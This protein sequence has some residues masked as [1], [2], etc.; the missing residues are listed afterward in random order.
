MSAAGISVG[1]DR[2]V[3]ITLR[4]IVVMFR[5][6]AWIWSLGLIAVMLGRMP[7]VNRPVLIG[8]AIVA[9]AWTGATVW[10]SAARNGR[11]W[12][13]VADGAIVLALSA[14]G[15]VAGGD[16]FI[17]GGLPASSLFVVAY[18][19]NLRWTMAAS[20]VVLVE[21]VV[22]HDLQNLGIQRT[23]GTYQFLVFGL[24]AGWSFDALRNEERRRLAAEAQLDDERRAAVRLEQGARLGQILHDSVLQTLLAIK[25]A[26]E[27][28]RH[29][30]YLARWQERELRR[31]I[32]ELR[33]PHDE[34]F[35]VELLA[36]R[37]GVEDLY[38]HTRVVD[39]IRD[40]AALTPSLRAGLSAAREA[41]TNAAKH[42]GVDRVDLYAEITDGWAVI[43]IRDRGRG[44]EVPHASAHQPVNS[45]RRGVDQVGGSV[46]IVTGP[47]QGTE[48][49]IRVPSA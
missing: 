31:T 48:V 8:A 23:V 43:H 34:S 2:P 4:W 22:L 47:G 41:L 20:I 3:Q 6:A 7:D 21:H 15:Y 45:M 5:V 28:P 27:D 25:N 35:R 11:V 12:F 32:E 29:V 18:T 13:A 19:A 16:D 38:T 26:A 36:I 40:D 33:S 14:A 44:F 46:D 17:S 39:V 10:S 49:T 30:R 24:L 1:P 42:A 9:T 37:D